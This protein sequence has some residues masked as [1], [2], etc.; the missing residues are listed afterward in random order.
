LL[1]GFFFAAAG[2]AFAA[3]LPLFAVAICTPCIGGRVDIS[4]RFF[5]PSASSVPATTTTLLHG[6]SEPA[7]RV[8]RLPL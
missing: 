5:R 2:F 4:L 7:F 1:A 8:E 6:V 3:P